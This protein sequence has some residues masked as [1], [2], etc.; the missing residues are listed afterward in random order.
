MSRRESISKLVPSFF[1]DGRIKPGPC[2]ASLLGGPFGTLIY[3]LYPSLD[4]IWRGF[5]YAVFIRV[6]EES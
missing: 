2:P 6:A 1:R 5:Y 3:R 4:A